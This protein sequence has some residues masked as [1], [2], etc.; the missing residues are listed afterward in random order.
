R[1]VA[2][3]LVRAC[4]GSILCRF[5]C[6]EAAVESPGDLA[7]MVCQRSRP[8]TDSHMVLASLFFLT[9]APGLFLCI[10]YALSTQFPVERGTLVFCFAC[11]MLSVVPVFGWTTLVGE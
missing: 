6:Q 5:R 3:I 4:A 9:V 11:G 10:R 8:M 2:V 7:L 1:G